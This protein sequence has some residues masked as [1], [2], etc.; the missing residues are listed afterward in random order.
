MDWA[1]VLYLICFFSMGIGGF[2]IPK[3]CNTLS[4]TLIIFGMFV[5]ISSIPVLLCID[6]PHD[7][8]K[9]QIPAGTCIQCKMKLK[10]TLYAVGCNGHQYTIN[11]S[12]W[13][14][15]NVS[16]CK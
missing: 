8:L 16:E 13:A 11:V 12:Q 6:L 5:G 15:L 3:R 14:F 2:I 10:D 1:W 9:N 7:R 4:W